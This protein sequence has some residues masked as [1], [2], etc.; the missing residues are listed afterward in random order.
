MINKEKITD[1]EKITNE[2]KQ[3]FK[4]LLKDLSDSLEKSNQKNNLLENWLDENLNDLLMKVDSMQKKN[5]MQEMLTWL[6]NEIFTLKKNKE[7]REIFEMLEK[8]LEDYEK[9]AKQEI[10]DE[11]SELQKIINP[12]DL[13]SKE[14]IQKADKWRENEAKEIW[15]IVSDLEKRGG[16]IGKLAIKANKS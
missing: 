8:K 5:Q 16:L 11:L 4:K 15:S 6:K 7:Y 3:D 13:N 14:M 1:K 10:K 9:K 2:E 12:K